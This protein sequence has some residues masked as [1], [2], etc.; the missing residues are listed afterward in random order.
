MNCE[1]AHE[2]IVTAVYGD[3]PDEQTHELERH[4]AGCQDCEHE[5]EQLLALKVLA[6]S[7]P[8]VE[9]NPNLIARSR[10]RLEEALDSLP[11]MRW[12]ER[13]AQRMANNFAS[14]RAAPAAALLLLV[15]GGGMGILAGYEYAQN[16]D[17]HNAAATHAVATEPVSQQET[18]AAPEIVRLSQV[19]SVVSI[20][21]VPN[22]HMVEVHFSR[23]V[24]ERIEGSLD[25]PAIRQLLML[26]SADAASAHVRDRSVSLMAAAC[27]AGRGCQPSGIR[28]ALMVAL[29]YD[30]NP[31]VR[32]T[33]L[34]G[35]ERYVSQDLRVRDAVL[36][37]L[38]NDADP[39]IRTTAIKILEPVEADTSVRQ[40][41]STVA[42]TDENP[43][44][45]LVS[46]EVLSRAPVIQ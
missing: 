24:P 30:R 9:P 2:R 18:A 15:A 34:D 8:V 22:S 7:Y 25:N 46:R 16:S 13:L 27:R 43:Q 3:L 4:M 33:A 26:A 40:V 14:L 36:E 38:L 23:L 42:T 10:L 17:A 29:R 32:M 45:R 6:N 11:P 31:D 37:A 35:L 21:Q 20:Q 28:D 41:L 39:A 44:I 5:R 19:A 1:V 12:Y